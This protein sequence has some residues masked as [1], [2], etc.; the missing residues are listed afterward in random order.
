MAVSRPTLLLNRI[1]SYRELSPLLVITDD[2][3]QSGRP[4]IRLLEEA[5]KKA[6]LQVIT[7]G[8]ESTC[9][10]CTVHADDPGQLPQPKP[11][12]QILKDIESR[13]SGT[14][15]VLI[16]LHEL[17]DFLT[18]SAGHLSTILSTL[19]AIHPGRICIVALF[20]ADIPLLGYPAHLPT[21]ETLL[22]FLATTRIQV[23]STHHVR[24]EREAASRAQTSVIELDL[25]GR[26][27]VLPALGCQDTLLYLEVEHR[28]RS[29]RGVHE[30][31]VLD[32]ATQQILTEEDVPALQL[33]SQQGDVASQQQ[34]QQTLDE[35][36]IPFKLS[37]S[38][39]EKQDREGVVLPH[40][41]MQDLPADERH[42][43][44]IYYEPDS[45]DDF[46]MEDPDDDLL[47]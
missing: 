3:K 23:R 39:K 14:S 17:N 26:D 42:G 21:P 19:L 10:V 15:K 2:V 13:I 31:C 4:V 45:G 46:D 11:I 24:L 18:T 29:G 1:L 32:T 8:W 5:A 7:V 36:D 33:H 44:H 30:R 41:T 22:S 12:E 43:G 16:A 27:I 40:F 20:H 9:A 38:E 6:S 25:E 47:L 28:R 34:Q 35:T 37:L